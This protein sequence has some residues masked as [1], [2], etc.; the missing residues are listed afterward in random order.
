MKV[1]FW[2]TS[3]IERGHQ[4]KIRERFPGGQSENHKF[5]HELQRDS[6]LLL[7]LPHYTYHQ[8]QTKTKVRRIFP[9]IATSVRS[10]VTHLFL[11]SLKVLLAGR[12][13]PD[14]YSVGKLSIRDCGHDDD[15]LWQILSLFTG[16]SSSLDLQTFFYLGSFLNCRA[17]FLYICSSCPSAH[18]S[19]S[20][21]HREKLNLL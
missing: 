19:K 14:E 9:G 8:N 2:I 20:L 5:T 17:F 7:A 6:S 10:T 18:Q 1:P 13:S 12:R 15:I 4:Q 21:D 11:V 3:S 16:P